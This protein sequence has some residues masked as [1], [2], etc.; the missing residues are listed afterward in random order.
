[1]S[2]GGEKGKRFSSLVRLSGDF[3]SRGPSTSDFTIDFGAGL[4]NVDRVSFVTCEFINSF[5]NIVS[6]VNNLFRYG[7]VVGA[8]LTTYDH[9]IPE[10]YYNIDDLLALLN[11]YITSDAATNAVL[12]YDSFVSKK[13]GATPPTVGD[14]FF[15]TNVSGA[16]ASDA[17]VW[18]M[19]G[20]VA[21][22]PPQNG[23]PVIAY[24]DTAIG[25]GVVAPDLPALRGLTEAYVQSAA[26]A[27]GNAYDE[28]GSLKNIALCVPIEA[29]YGSLVIFECKQDPLCQVTYP[30]P[31]NIQS[32]D[33]QLVDRF[34]SV[35][36]LRGANFKLDL[37]VWYN[38]K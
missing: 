3:R 23:V 15:I 24:E 7:V 12:L 26:L 5:Y 16:D 13:V 10:G 34:G 36:N 14:V 28:K 1:M 38:S 9:L 20:F 2:T 8:V 32:I 21:N 17:T 27:P 29:A 31:R 19:L 33:I 11:A 4:Q 22:L 37:R 35:L 25:T 6:G 30:T 18:P